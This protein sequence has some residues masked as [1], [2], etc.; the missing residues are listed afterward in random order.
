VTGEI[1]EA[2]K[3]AVK[4]TNQTISATERAVGATQGPEL[5]DK[6]KR[7]RNSGMALW[8][9]QQHDAL[10]IA[11]KLEDG[12]LKSNGKR[13]TTINSS[14][15]KQ[16]SIGTALEHSQ[17]R[18]NTKPRRQWQKPRGG[19]GGQ[20]IVTEIM[21]WHL[22][23][24]G[25]L[26][27]SDRLQGREEIQLRILGSH[28]TDSRT[29]NVAPAAL[30]ARKQK[31]RWMESVYQMPLAGQRKVDKLTA[32]TPCWDPRQMDTGAIY[33]L[34]QPENWAPK[35]MRDG[36]LSSEWELEGAKRLLSS[37]RGGS[38]GAERNMN[39]EQIPTHMN[40]RTILEE[41]WNTSKS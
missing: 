39:Q 23:S 26:R 21:E 33:R 17:Y 16:N 37:D 14:L 19:D 8:E 31:Q 40:E 18:S 6:N 41:S 34:G 10:G 25:R 27:D 38:T 22:Q 28:T 7:Q 1:V 30:H 11:T 12:N 36:V 4:D 24:L 2:T 32:P 20:E 5:R 13:Y 9:Q 35:D 29:D 3:R 15:A